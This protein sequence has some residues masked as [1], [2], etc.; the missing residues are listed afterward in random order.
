M[1]GR[2]LGSEYGGRNQCDPDTQPHADAP[3]HQRAEALCQSQEQRADEEE[4]VGQCD[5]PSPPL[6]IGNGAR[7]D[8][9]NGGCYVDHPDAQLQLH[10]REAQVLLQRQH[11]PSDDALIIA[12]N[13]RRDGRQRDDPDQELGA[14]DPGL[15]A[16]LRCLFC[17]R[18]LAHGRRWQGVLLAGPVHLAFAIATM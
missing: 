15:L 8:S 12:G 17:P 7:D 18:R 6:R 10:A 14:A 11:G 16:L 9:A 1:G 5:G 13:D 4:Q 3:H 2:H